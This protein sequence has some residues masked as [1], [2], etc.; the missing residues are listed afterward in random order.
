[1]K[2]A[3]ALEHP[4]PSGRPGA[5]GTGSDPKG[6]GR[7]RALCAAVAGRGGRPLAQL[8]PGTV[9]AMSSL[10]TPDGERP[11]RRESSPTSAG[12]GG[13]APTSPDQ[14]SDAGQA[15][16]PLRAAAAAL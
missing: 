3:G 5:R 10:W 15:P 13:S 7:T 9:P 6:P 4:P 2:R 1:T 11:V 8:K 14:A 16:D 12:E